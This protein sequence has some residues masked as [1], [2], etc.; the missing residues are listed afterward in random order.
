MGKKKT[1]D[2]VKMK[3]QIQARLRKERAGMT[4]EQA[5]ADIRRKLATSDSPAARLWRKVS[6]GA[7]EPEREP[8]ATADDRRG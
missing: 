1:F 5:G 4:D 2:C 8:E 6:T 3:D 7:A